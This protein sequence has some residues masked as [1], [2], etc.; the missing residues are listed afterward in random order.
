LDNNAVHAWII[1]H[2]D[3]WL[4]VVLYIGLSV[5]LSIW[6]SLFWLVA[7]IGVHFCLEYY[8]QKHLRSGL[9]NILSE[10]FWE[11]KLDFALI[12]FA[13][14]LALYM[15]IILGIVGIGSVSRLSL[16]GRVGSRLGVR[17]S[18]QAGVKALPRF[19]GWQRTVR[20]LFLSL[21]DIA[22][23]L[24]A[25]NSRRRSVS[26]K[27]GPGILVENRVSQSLIGE[28]TPTIELASKA[29]LGSW[30]GVWAHSDWVAV[31]MGAICL[32]LIVSVP[33]ITDHTI[34]SAVHLLL[35]ELH[36]FAGL[37]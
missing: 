2:D 1:N 14:A 21:D 16:F 12:L 20:G 37:K 4:F 31:I 27:I 13:M 7:V 24:R 23:V 28:E 33:I 30:S 9:F 15:D 6:I 5:I 32:A 11:L 26:P 3:K 34:E 29:G 36:P 22:Q 8:R 17:T 18:V 35:E 10:T 25:I 19:A